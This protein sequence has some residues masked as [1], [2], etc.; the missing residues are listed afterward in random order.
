MTV[1]VIC[2]EMVALQVFRCADIHIGWNPRFIEINANLATNFK[3][4]IE[5]K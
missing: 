2:T 3:W 4:D 1:I 5:H